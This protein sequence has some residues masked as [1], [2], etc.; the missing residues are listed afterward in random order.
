MMPEVD[1]DGLEA[2]MATIA[3]D[4]PPA[5]AAG[6]LSAVRALASVYRAAAGSL[7]VLP[8][9]ADD[10]R[11][12][13]AHGAGEQEIV[14]MTVSRGTGIA[15]WV[16]TSG[17]TLAVADVR[18]DPRFSR[19]T[20]EATGYVPT[21]ILAAPILDDHGEAIGVVEVLDPTVRERDLDLLALVGSLLAFPLV[22]VRPRS[23]P[24]REAVAA[25]ET[26]GPHAEELAVALLRAVSAHDGGRR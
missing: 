19:R 15:G 11:F 26:L 2:R 22:Q 3:P 25:I 5:V 21:T 17:T 14:G 8:P 18:R 12:V 7:A 13:A 4:L 23:S 16:A 1:S 9:D 20:A 10:L 24:L 6:L